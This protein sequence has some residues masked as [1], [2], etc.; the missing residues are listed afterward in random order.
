MERKYGS[1]IQS[2]SSTPA[3]INSSIRRVRILRGSW[4]IRRTVFSPAAWMS[5]ASGRSSSGNF[6][7]VSSH[8]PAKAR[9]MSA[10]AG[11]LTLTAVSL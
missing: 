11:P 3:V 7:A 5:F 4:T 2:R 10:T 9:S 1:V 6:S 8:T